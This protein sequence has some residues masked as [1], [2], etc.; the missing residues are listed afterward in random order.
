M[1][2]LISIAA[3]KPGGVAALRST[4]LKLYRANV[5]PEGGNVP[6]KA[7]HDAFIKKH[8]QV[9]GALFEDPKLLRFGELEQNIA[10]SSRIAERVQATLARSPPAQ[11]GGIAPQRSGKA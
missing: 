4:V 6:S 7:L 10:R 2:E 11:F 3:K 9:L 5:I 8:E 1:R